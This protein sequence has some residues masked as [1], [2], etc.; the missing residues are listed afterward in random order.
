MFSAFIRLSVVLIF[1]PSVHSRELS[2]ENAADHK[3]RSLFSRITFSV[4]MLFSF[5][6]YDEREETF[7]TSK[8]LRATA[9]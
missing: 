6:L 1:F 2:I 4:P 9:V 5:H 8:I 3:V 7:R